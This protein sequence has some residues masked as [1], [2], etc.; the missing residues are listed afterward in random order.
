MTGLT[1]K[2]RFRSDNRRPFPEWKSMLLGDVLQEE[3]QRN[4]DGKIE[5]VLSVTNHS[6]FVLPEV[7]HSKRVA[8]ENVSNYKIVRRGQYGY[9]PSRLNVGSFARLD[10][11]EE[12]IV[13]PMY[14]VFSIDTS[15]VDSGYFLNWMSS[16]EAKQLIA[17][18]TQG[19]VRNSVN[20]DALCDFPFKLPCLE[21]QRKIAQFLN[22]IQCKLSILR[23]KQNLMRRCKRGLTQKIFNQELRFR[24]DNRRPFPEWKSMLLGDVLQEEKQRNKDGKIERVLSV[25]N[26]SGFVL[27]EVQHSKRVASENVSNYK[28][29]R[30]GQY[31]YNPSRLNVGSFA[32][33]DAYEEGIVSPMYVVFSIDTS[34]VDSGYFSIG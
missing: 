5:R 15:R 27:P 21:E 13:S 14:V 33:L 23:E 11:Y 26:H 4:K 31:G 17:G 24:S 34:R 18:S 3:K 30:R 20:F 7:Q 16:G 29:V 32:R 22:V 10:A 28:I 19:S 9:N 6:G 2:L 8:S 12:G 25:T 1:P